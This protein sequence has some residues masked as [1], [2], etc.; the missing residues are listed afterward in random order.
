MEEKKK[1]VKPEAEIIDFSSEDIIT[2]SS[3][4]RIAGFEDGEDF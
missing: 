4:D 3:T 2:L 1:Y